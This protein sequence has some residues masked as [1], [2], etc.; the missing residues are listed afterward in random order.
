MAKYIIKMNKIGKLNK[1]VLIEG[2][3]GIG[4][5]ARIAVDYLIH[6]LRAKEF[7]TIYSYSFPNSVFLNEDNTI[8]LPKV[9]LF[10]WKNRKGRDL[11]LLTGDVQPPNEEDSYLLAEKIL[12]ISKK[13]GV[14]EVITLGGIG[15][16]SEPKESRV[17]GAVTDKKYKDE[18]K[19]L[20]V[21]MNGN[22]VVG[23]IVGAAG[24]LLGLGKLKGM[25]GISLLAETFAHPA[26]IG[27]RGSKS[28]LQ[29]LSKYLKLDIDFRELDKE[30]HKIEEVK[31][32]RE[33]ERMKKITGEIG[34]LKEEE[35]HRYIG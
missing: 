16:M 23:A 1:P 33:S 2:L 17:H 15:L 8:D 28:I 14:R 20:G 26:Y 32:K 18:L 27:I 10:Y 5:V 19:K 25:K 4:N 21:V 6:K 30:I 7:V 9:Q 29:I 35:E 11:I 24:L 12:E 22:G 13:L 31:I 3:P 34:I